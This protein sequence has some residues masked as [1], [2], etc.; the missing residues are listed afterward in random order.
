[1]REEDRKEKKDPAREQQDYL[2]EWLRRDDKQR[3]LRPH[4]VRMLGSAT[5][6]VEAMDALRDESPDMARELDGQIGRDT[7]SL[8]SSLVL[9]PD[10]DVD[11]TTMGVTS[12]VTS[13]NAAVYDAMISIRGP[14]GN[15]ESFPAITAQIGHYER[16]ASEQYRAEEAGR[17]VA[18]LFP[19]LA[20]RYSA[21]RNAAKVAA[22]NPKSEEAAASEMRT[23][24]YKLKGEL[25]AKAYKHAGEN[26]MSWLLMAGRLSTALGRVILEEQEQAHSHLVDSLSRMLKARP[27][28]YSF[29]S[30]W[31]QF[32]DHVYIVCGVLLGRPVK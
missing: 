6:Q 21:V 25:F 24:L 26:K 31:T 18:A 1:M 13:G 4:V 15:A 17:R 29:Q 8:I 11:A 7:A 10:W 22:G 23:F 9:P 12:T 32:A 19:N 14:A 3:A 30:V 20:E 27:T 2:E 5:W 28:S 16:L